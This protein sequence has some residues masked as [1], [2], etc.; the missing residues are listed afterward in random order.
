MLHSRFAGL[1]LSLW[2]RL[3]SCIYYVCSFAYP[4]TSWSDLIYMLCLPIDSG[5]S[6]FSG[7]PASPSNWCSFVT[8]HP[9]LLRHPTSGAPSSPYI[10]CSYVT[11]VSICS[12]QH[13][14]FVLS[15]IG[16]TVVGRRS[17]DFSRFLLFA[18]LAS[19]ASAFIIIWLIVGCI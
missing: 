10:R 15:G 5:M 6:R 12:L 8:L 11:L 1:R 13:L 14:S 7:A 17:S 4:T 2:L 9:V 19:C 16:S 3:Q 18:H